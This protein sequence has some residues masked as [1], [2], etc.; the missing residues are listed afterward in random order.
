MGD[1]RREDNKIKSLGINY[2]KNRK[3]NSVFMKSQGIHWEGFFESRDYSV[4][5]DVAQKL[6]KINTEVCIGFEARKISELVT[7]FLWRL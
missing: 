2:E 1:V 4:E 5:R 6:R 7:Q 3:P